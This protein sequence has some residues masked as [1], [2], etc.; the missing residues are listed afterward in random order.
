MKEALPTTN[1]VWTCE[2]T[3]RLRLAGTRCGG[4]GRG[5]AWCGVVRRGGARRGAA[6]RG[7]AGC[8]D[9]WGG[10][11]EARGARGIH[12]SHCCTFDTAV[13]I[14]VGTSWHSK[15]VARRSGAWRGVAVFGMGRHPAV[16]PEQLTCLTA[17]KGCARPGQRPAEWLSPRQVTRHAAPRTLSPELGHT[18][19]SRCGWRCGCGC[20]CGGGGG[21]LGFRWTSRLETGGG[22]GESGG[23]RGGGRGGGVCGRVRGGL[24]HCVIDVRPRSP[25]APSLRR[26]WMSVSGSD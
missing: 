14:V 22:W 13:S 26:S 8:G 21:C 11:R 20:G 7:A 24:V 3:L 12:D 18:A 19:L 23:G 16:P 10:M 2:Q 15:V 1:F 6:W 25:S 4:A 9:E 5:G 17:L